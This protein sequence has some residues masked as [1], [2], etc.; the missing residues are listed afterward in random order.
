[1]KFKKESIPHIAIFVLC[2][3]LLFLFSFSSSASSEQL[4]RG[5]IL[6]SKTLIPT[7]F[8][9]MVISEM[10]V[11]SGAASFI[12]PAIEKVTKKLFGISGAGGAAMILGILCGFPVGAKATAELYQN[13]TITKREAERLM[14]ICNLPSPPFVIFAVGEKLFGSRQ[15]GLLLYFNILAVTLILGM[16]GKKSVTVGKGVEYRKSEPIFTLFT[17]SVSSASGAVIKVCA[18]VT[19]FSA[20]IGGLSPIFQKVSPILKAVV[21]SFFELTSGV[22]ACSALAER[23]KGLI[24]AS[25]AAGWSGLSVFCQIFSISRTKDE[26][27]SMRFYLSS[28]IISSAVCGSI[29]AMLIKIF[30]TLIPSKQTADS[31]VSLISLYPSAFVIAANIIF[32][33]SLFIYFFKN[34]DRRHII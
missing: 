22:S 13:G 32:I 33:L 6:C 24:I 2:S 17:E 3:A 4:Y 20:L 8:P 18:Y 34:L 11:R 29:T 1:M 26:S 25:A 21:F 9:Y 10:L 30:P 31:T 5:L 16:I 14:G 19:F 28:K 15:I 12:S 23:E 27:I 7:L